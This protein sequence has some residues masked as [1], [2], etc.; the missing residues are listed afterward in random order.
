M[1]VLTS[2]GL[3]TATSM[4]GGNPPHLWWTKHSVMGAYMQVPKEIFF[5]ELLKGEP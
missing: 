5:T 4:Q 3:E 1:M 2:A